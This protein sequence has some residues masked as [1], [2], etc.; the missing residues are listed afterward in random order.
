MAADTGCNTI[1][2]G[3]EQT[4]DQG[5]DIIF[6]DALT[7]LVGCPDG[8]PQVLYPLSAVRHVS[9]AGNTRYLLS[10]DEQVLFEL[11]RR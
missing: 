2:A 8:E 7:T 9:G 4:G 3:Y 5:Q 11:T 6:K 10:D 1:S